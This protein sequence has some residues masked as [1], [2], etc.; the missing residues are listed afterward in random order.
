LPSLLIASPKHSTSVEGRPQCKHL[1]DAADPDGAL[2]ALA[3]DGGRLAAQSLAVGDLP[4][5]PSGATLANVWQ[6]VVLAPTRAVARRR[7]V[8]SAR[9]SPG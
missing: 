7:A 5:H 3:D 8:G 1:D 4:I 9:A 2:V 6:D